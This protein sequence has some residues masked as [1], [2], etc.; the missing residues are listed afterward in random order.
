MSHAIKTALIWAGIYMAIKLIIVL[1]GNHHEHYSIF[2]GFAANSMCLLLAIALA[3][4]SNFKKHKHNGL[5]LIVD[6]KTGIKTGVVYSIVISAFLLS[7][8]KWIDPDYVRI[9]KEKRIEYAENAPAE[10]IVETMQNDPEGF[11]D[12]STKDVREIEM[13]N[14]EFWIDT[15]KVFPITLMSLIVI[16][17]FY[18]FLV[19]AFNRLVLAK[20]G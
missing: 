9:I 20:L 15:K 4:I 6:L 18:S 17:I 3:I 19:T 11:K 12:K 5:S 8:Y 2:L 7:Y 16:S 10:N 1:S 14:T 13:D